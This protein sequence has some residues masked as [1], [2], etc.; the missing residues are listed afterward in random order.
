MYIHEI[1]MS[2]FQGLQQSIRSQ[3]MFSTK[4][5]RGADGIGYDGA[6]AD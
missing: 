5:A 2:S 3:L 1:K 6:G 4:W